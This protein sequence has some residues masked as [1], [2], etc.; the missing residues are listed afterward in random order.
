MYVQ[1][2]NFNGTHY[3]V[4]YLRFG[5]HDTCPFDR[6]S[7]SCIESKGV[8]LNIMELCLYFWADIMVKIIE[9]RC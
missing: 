9:D 7:L 4:M 6:A 3:V 1:K 5:K 2:K 8:K